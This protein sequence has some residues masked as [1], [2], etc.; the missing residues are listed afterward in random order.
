LPVDQ[1]EKQLIYFKG[2]FDVVPLEMLCDMKQNNINP[3]R[4]TIALTFDDGFLNNLQIALPLLE[5]YQLP[6]TFF[7][8]SICLEDRSYIHPSDFFNL[9][10]ATS[11]TAQVRINE[12]VFKKS[13]YHLVN[14]SNGI[15]A[16]QYINSL[17]YNDWKTTL[18]NLL[19]SYPLQILANRVDEEAYELIGKEHL[20]Q[21]GASSV[22]SIGSHCHSHVNIKKLSEDEM[23]EQFKVSKEM[24]EKCSLKPVNTIAYPYGYYNKKAIELSKE[25]GYKYL[26]A[27]GDV[28]KEFKNDLFPRIAIQSAGS[29]ARNILSINKGFTRFGF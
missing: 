3:G 20:I 27:A 24:L 11:E 7:C 5:K 10:A 8:C 9:I 18:L 22:A 4:H 29:Y 28:G 13:K 17:S 6:A 23:R 21:I 1:F 19:T 2:N 26:F 15:T 12:K 25:E 16:D 14:L